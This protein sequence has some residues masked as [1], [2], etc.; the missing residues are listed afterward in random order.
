LHF[1]ILALGDSDQGVREAAAEALGKIGA[2]KAIPP[3]IQALGDSAW[4]VRWAAARALGELVD[5]VSDAEVIRRMARTLW[6]RLTDWKD[7]RKAAS[8]ALEKVANRLA[9]LDIASHPL[10]DPFMPAQSATRPRWK[11]VIWAMPPLAILGLLDLFKGVLTNLLSDRL[12]WGR[13]PAGTAGLLLLIL[14][15]LVL[16][17]TSQLVTKEGA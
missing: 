9:I 17:C 14:G 2:P 16:F 5:N 11:R 4:G 3:L 8:W 7:V 1:E 13:L 6:Q 10:R 12:Q 15:S